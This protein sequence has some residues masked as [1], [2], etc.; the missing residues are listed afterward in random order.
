MQVRPAQRKDLNSIV[1]LGNTVSEFQVSDEVV[2]FWPKEIVERCIKDN[3]NPIIVAVQDDEIVGFIIA[4]YNPSFKKAIIENVFVSPEYRGQKVGESLLERLVKDLRELGC[5]YVCTLIENQSTFAIDFYKRN[6]FS[7]G[8]DCAWL[9]RVL[10]ESFK[11]AD[12][13]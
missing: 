9:D 8:I 13:S 11:K 1:R 6:G 4:N 10:E 2:T 3:Q 5:E 7:R 12:L